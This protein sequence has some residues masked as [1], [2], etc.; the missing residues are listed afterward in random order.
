MNS[1]SEIYLYTDAS[2]SKAH[3]LAVGG[4]I[5]FKTRAEHEGR[6][7]PAFKRTLSFEERNNIRAE[8]RAASQALA[9][10]EETRP[11]EEWANAEVHLYS[12]CQTVTELPKRR[13]KLE[14]TNF[15]SGR[16]GKALANKD[17]YLEFFRLFDLISPIIH[18]LPGHSPKSTQSLEQ[19]H[20]SFLDKLVRKK[21]RENIN[22]QV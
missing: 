17:L 10:I 6:E 3:T 5:L 1:S 15:I 16:T 13:E 8:V 19:H 21:L 11:K 18:W 2:F 12:D 4:W 7:P 14:R 22:S 20:F 9:Y